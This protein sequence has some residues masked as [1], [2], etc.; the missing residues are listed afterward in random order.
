MFRKIRLFLLITLFL[1]GLPACT[2]KQ[3][4][5]EKQV[6]RG[7]PPVAVDIAEVAS[8][9]ITDGIEVIGSLAPK[10]QAEIKSEY[11]GIVTEVFVNEWVQVAKGA[12]LAQLDTREIR[13]M[14]QKA[15]AVLSAARAGLLQAK[16]ASTRADREYQRFS[17][18]KEA[19][20][21]TQQALD[22]AQSTQEAAS[23]A[24]EAIK[25]QIA[26][27][28][29]DV[30]HTQTRLEKA[31][32]RAPRDGVIAMRG[33]NVGDLAGEMGSPK[34]MFLIVDNRVMNLTVTVPSTRMSSLPPWLTTPAFAGAGSALCG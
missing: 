34:I 25:A 17:K 23:A 2:P 9:T 12:P 19:G 7:K 33:V 6:R 10:F 30:L 21:V 1:V 15:E 11:A 20:L 4:D 18:M 28:E 13:V 8:A 31:T 26:V 32:I 3:P 14:M 22:E 5:P 29:K 27:A 16:V 24:M